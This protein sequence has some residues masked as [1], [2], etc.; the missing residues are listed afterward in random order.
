MVARELTKDS[1]GEINLCRTYS[2]ESYKLKQVETDIVYGSE[3][4]DV[5]EGYDNNGVPYSRFTYI[6]TNE[7]DENETTEETE[8]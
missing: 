2:T 8:V 6:E 1:S 7:K 5:I 4:I 3:A